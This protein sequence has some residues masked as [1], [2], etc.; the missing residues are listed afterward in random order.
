MS[1]ERC[2]ELEKRLRDGWT[3]SVAHR[4]GVFVT[5]LHRRKPQ[6]AGNLGAYWA[7]REAGKPTRDCVTATGATLAESTENLLA[8]PTP[9]GG[10]AAKP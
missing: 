9:G 3:V 5:R 7:A 4:Q 1:C 2:E 10:D 8:H 6:Y